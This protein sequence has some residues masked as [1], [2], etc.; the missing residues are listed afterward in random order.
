[1][2]PHVTQFETRHRLAVDELSLRLARGTRKAHLRRSV[3]MRPALLAHFERPL[4][5]S[6]SIRLGR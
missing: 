3:R 2:Y 6:E 1:M 5:L 4:F